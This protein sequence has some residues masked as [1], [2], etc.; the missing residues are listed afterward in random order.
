[1]RTLLSEQFAP[2]TSGIGFLELPLDE[3]VEGLSAWRHELFGAIDVR[4]LSD[5][6]PASLLAL[7]PLT[8][9][10]RA[11][12]LVVQT[13]GN[14]TAYFDCS[15]RGTDAVSAIGHLSRTLRCQ[16]LA[17][18]SVTHMV[19][20]PGVQNGRAGAVQ[21]ELFS[22]LK[23][24][25]INYVRTISVTSNG[26]KW[27]FDANGL[28]QA[29][30]EPDAYTKRSI[31]ERFT[32]EMLER[33]CQAIGVDVFDPA[34]YGPRAVLFDSGRVPPPA[35]HV[36]TLEQAQQWLEIRPGAADELPG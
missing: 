19:G 27:R 24:D 20:Y 18:K 13:R 11:R 10:I 4:E 21:F 5:G 1:M 2:I 16:G 34:F 7:Q 23:T 12:E 22:P 6:F 9:G 14:W 26:T 36:M 17:V 3:V 32:S 25:F 30:E 31:R 28:E 8:G 29:F 15:L 33:Y 35:A